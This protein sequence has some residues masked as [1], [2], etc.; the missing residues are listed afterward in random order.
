VYKQ[1]S[2]ALALYCPFPAHISPF[3]DEVGQHTLAWGREYGLITEDGPNMFCTEQHWRLM[4]YVYPTISCSDLE[5]VTDWNTWG[6]ALD[7]FLDQATQSHRRIL[8][9]IVAIIKGKHSQNITHPLCLALADLWQ[10]LQRR[11]SP[12]WCSQLVSTLFAAFESYLWQKENYRRGEY[13]TRADYLE[14]RVQ[15]GAWL[16][17]L[18][19]H[20]LFVGI[21]SIPLSDMPQM[22]QD[23][24]RQVNQTICIANDLVSYP[25][26]LAENDPHNLVLIVQHED[27]LSLMKSV[28]VV[29]MYHDSYMHQSQEIASQLMNNDDIAIEVRVIASYIDFAEAFLRGNLEWSRETVR[30]GQPKMTMYARKSSLGPTLIAIATAL[31]C[32]I[33]FI[34]SVGLYL[35]RN[36]YR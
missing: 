27:H 32:G 8:A 31:G 29:S 3:V 23:Y 28:D 35:H 2:K 15:T 16:T 12:A 25:K 5:L 19:F 13:P 24:L 6:F 17:Y 20:E 33:I 30:Y 7:D 36:Q 18:R 9:D 1:A 14:Q 22:L 4:A 21:P 11:A 26:E 34:S 10:R